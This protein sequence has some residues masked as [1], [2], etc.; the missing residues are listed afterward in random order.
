M[1]RVVI[2]T[3]AGVDDSIAIAYASRLPDATIELMTTVSGNVPVSE[4]TQNVLYLK[5][6]LRLDVPV[7]SGADVPKS[8]KLITA[9]EVHG[10]DG[11]GG[12]RISEGIAFPAWKTG[13]AATAIVRAAKKYGKRL[14]IISLG[15]MTNIA[16]A[17]SID[18]GAIKGI[19]S[20]VQMGGVFSG[21][22]NTTAFTEFNIFVDP[23]AASYVLENG[24]KVTFVPLDLTETF[25]LPRNIVTSLLMKTGETSPE[26]VPLFRKALNYYIDYHRHADKLDG[27]YMHD[28]I[29]V[30]AAIHPE[31]FRFIGSSVS[32]ETLGRFT[33]GMTVADLRK[34]TVR[35]NSRIAVAFDAL[36]FL[37]DLA[38]RVFGARIGNS[39]GRRSCLR[40]RFTANFRDFLR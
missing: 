22:G 39:A 38:S 32:I 15:P 33:A 10:K 1:R 11:V 36:T 9:T 14:T 17:V 5:K 26:L 40:Q 31:W 12:Y 7:F 19:G 18:Q 34:K 2:D 3:D 23:E 27:C 30:A 35:G 8:R 24:V 4:V 28:P 16:R 13:G 25:F 6:I 37:D 21:Y 29:A 20:I